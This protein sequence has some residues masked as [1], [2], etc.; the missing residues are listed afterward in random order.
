MCEK[1]EALRFRHHF[2]IN[3]GVLTICTSLNHETRSVKV[4]WSLFNPNDQRWVR[5]QGNDNARRRLNEFPLEFILTQNEPI[6]CD[7]ISLRALMLVFAAAK[8]HPH[9]PY[10][11]DSTQ[12]IPRQVLSVL[13]YEMIRI[14]SLLGQRLNLPSIT[15]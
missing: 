15:E 8:R 11:N 13:Q 1:K 4:G 9:E 6:L 7:Y 14:I 3:G 5:R 10:T 12:V 2:L